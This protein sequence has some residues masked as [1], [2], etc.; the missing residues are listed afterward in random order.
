LVGWLHCDA[1]AIGGDPLQ[2]AVA[3]TIACWSVKQAKDP[4]TLWLQLWTSELKRLA[5]LHAHNLMRKSLSTFPV[6]QPLA[7]DCQWL[8]LENVMLGVLQD[9]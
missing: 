2:S 8:L 9:A 1:A 5:S 3:F 7:D 4:N 6:Q